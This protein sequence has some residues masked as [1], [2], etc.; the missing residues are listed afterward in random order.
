MGILKLTDVGAISSCDERP[1]VTSL[2]RLAVHLPTDI[3]A[4]RLVLFGML[5]SCL[6]DAIIMA[7]ALSVQEIFLCPSRMFVT[8][9]RSFVQ[10]LRASFD[11]RLK[12]DRG[13]YSELIAVRNAYID[14]IKK[15]RSLDF[16]KRNSISSHRMHQLDQTIFE[17]S[18]RVQD[19]LRDLSKRGTPAHVSLN[20]TQLTRRNWGTSD[21]AIDTNQ[22][23]PFESDMLLLKFII[24]MAFSPQFSVGLDVGAGDPKCKKTLQSYGFDPRH[25]LI[26][27]RVPHNVSIEDLKLAIEENVGNFE[28]LQRIDKS[29]IAIQFPEIDVVSLFLQLCCKRKL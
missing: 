24:A 11:A 10:Q 19:Y 22:S 14:W 2:G 9:S 26:L 3:N 13:E 7:G 27:D 20:I 17:I 6:H 8:S 28:K 25:T 5:F 12:F 16:L 21:D 4:A 29:R 23:L 15:R 18:T 1:N